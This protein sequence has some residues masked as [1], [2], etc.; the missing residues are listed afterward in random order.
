MKKK[1]DDYTVDAEALDSA[2]EPNSRN[3]TEHLLASPANAERL[4][5][6]IRSSLAG[7]GMVMSVEDLRTALGLGP[8]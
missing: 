3:D 2:C 8:R 6:A 1:K 5:S 7:E 4:R